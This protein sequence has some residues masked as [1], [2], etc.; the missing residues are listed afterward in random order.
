MS[1][2]ARLAN[3]AWLLSGVRATGRFHAALR[4]PDDAQW[5]WLHAQLRRNAACEYGVQHDFGGIASAGEFA[6]RVPLVDYADIEPQVQRIAH[7]ASG[8]LTSD[9]VTHLAPTSGSTGA[10][11]LIPFGRALQ[12]GFDAAINPWVRDLARQR[13]SMRG[14]PAYW[15]V[16]PLTDADAAE[17]AHVPVGFAND[18]DYLGGHAAWLVHQM[19]AVPD[20]IR[21]VRSVDAFKALTLLALLRRRDLRVISIWHPSFLDLLT[22]AAIA[23]WPVLLDAIAS[24]G[25]PWADALPQRAR[26]H[27]SVAPDPQRAA[28]LRR[29]GPDDWPLWWPALQVVSCWG[30]QAAAPGWSRLRTRLPHVLVQAKGLLATEGVITI[31]IGDAYPL[32]ITSHYLEFLDRDGDPRRASALERG[33]QYEVVVTNGGG[34]WRY[35]LGDVVEC[36][37]HLQATPTLRFLGRGSGSSDLRGEKLTEVFVAT[38]LRDL[39]NGAASPG[40]AALQAADGTRGAGYVLLVSDDVGGD[41]E[42]LAARLD[43]ALQANPHY[44][45]AR[46]LGQLNQAV[47]RRVPPDQAMRELARTSGRL[48]DAKPRLLLSADHPGPLAP[49]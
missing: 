13:P 14:G 6:R 8:V 39:W 46:R 3:A 47:V 44:A 24:G 26:A 35:R 17:P 21:H 11:K 22:T 34:L 45:L 43:Q 2:G 20:A 36:T 27:W 23:Q 30:D 29:I 25:C 33:G 4:A 41:D 18:A 28:E 32:A 9:R 38:V 42:A 40:Y 15:S 16:S 10:R 12:A 19:M 49:G 1:I 31:P 5:T 37:G 7:G 48:G